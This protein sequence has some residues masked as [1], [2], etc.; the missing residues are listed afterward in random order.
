MKETLYIYCSYYDRSINYSSTNFNQLCFKLQDYIILQLK[1]KKNF[2][3]ILYESPN[4]KQKVIHYEPMVKHKIPHIKFYVDGEHNFI[5]KH[6]KNAGCMLNECISHMKTLFSYI[7]YVDVVMHMNDAQ[8]INEYINSFGQNPD[9]I[10]FKIMRAKN[11]IL[12]HAIE[13]L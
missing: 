13:S 3:I 5:V 1:S 4:V 9:Y 12:K 10:F 7:D 6:S 8:I 2:M 11:R